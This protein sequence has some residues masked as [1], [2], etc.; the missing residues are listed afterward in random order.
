MRDAEL[1]RRFADKLIKVRLLDGSEE[2]LLVHI[3]VQGQRDLAF[4]KRMFVYAYRLYDRYDRE[5]VSL[6]VL[7]DTVHGWRPDGFAVG[8]WGSRLGISFPSVKL[9]DYAAR[10]AELETDE[11]PFA[12]VVLA[13]LAAQ[14]TRGDDQARYARKLFL[15][16][17]LYERGLTRQQIIDLYRFIDW[18]LRLPDDLELQ[19]TNEVFR[20]EE[21]LQ[22][23]YVS[24]VERRGIELGEARGE[25]RG[26]ARLLRGL[27]ERR[28]GSLPPDALARLDDADVERL[29][30][31][32]ERVFDARTL[33]EVFVDDPRVNQG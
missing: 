13:H 8:R 7:A 5:I 23:P 21:G 24:F 31:W 18:I 17:R 11:N 20:I 28:F 10:Q 2:W 27:L 32:S 29:M 4:A 25:V 3:E 6:A 9:L 12:T 14:A 22:M 16:R 19:Y 33:A 15:T 30:A 26:S 1:G